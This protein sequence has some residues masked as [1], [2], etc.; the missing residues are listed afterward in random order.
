MPHKNYLPVR[1]KR[2]PGG[3]NRS[4]RKE[5]KTNPPA[6]T[7]R[8][9]VL[10]V[11]GERPSRRGRQIQSEEKTNPPAGS[12]PAGSSSAGSSSRYTPEKRIS[13]YSC[14]F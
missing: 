6:G 4:G 10:P 12:S 14:G 5:E 8:T 7:T 3:V 11:R 2:P 9:G 1:G 13:R